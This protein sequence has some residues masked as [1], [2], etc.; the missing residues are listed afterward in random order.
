[1]MALDLTKPL[2]M[3]T[4]TRLRQKWAD[5]TDRRQFLAASLSALKGRSENFCWY[6]CWYNFIFTNFLFDITAS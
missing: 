1:M 4:G 5:A 2:A 3:F 6:I